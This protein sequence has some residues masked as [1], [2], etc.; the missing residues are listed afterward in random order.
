MPGAGRSESAVIRTL[1][2]VVALLAVVGYLVF[3]WS[4]GGD[5]D[6]VPMVLGAAI[7]IVAIGWGLYTRVATD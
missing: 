5:S 3:G 2:A 1:G 7:A 6:I 4:F